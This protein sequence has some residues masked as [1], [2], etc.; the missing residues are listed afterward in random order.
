M[1]SRV[2]D[3]TGAARVRPA[4]QPRAPQAVGGVMRQARDRFPARPAGT[5]WAM[6]C[7]SAEEVIAALDRP[8]FRAE[9]VHTRWERRSGA[10][11]I[12]H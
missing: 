10:R 9:N 12:L 1:K 11:A 2:H 7:A 5:R 3:M 6:T 4:E 8:P